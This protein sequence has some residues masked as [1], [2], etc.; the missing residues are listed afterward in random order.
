MS[1]MVTDMDGP[2]GHAIGNALEVREAID[3]LR[4]H[5]P[6]DFTTLCLE[7]AGH[8]LLLGDKTATAE[9]GVARARGALDD[10]AA[11]RVFQQLIAAQDG[12]P[13]F[14]G[15]GLP[16]AP[17][18]VAVTAPADGYVRRVDAL[19]LGV[20]ARDLGA[21]RATKS[22]A[23]DPAVGLIAHRKAGDRVRQGEALA[24]LHT[25]QHDV[26]TIAAWETRC[27]DAFALD[28]SAPAPRPLIH[29]VL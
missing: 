15:V 17:I 14:D 19:A 20:L 7:L 25:G 10:G 1:A 9:E 5:G 4:G 26:S 11:L 18:Q 13:N 8:M 22:D 6:D 28:G 16:E 3:T 24:T 27:R 21:G 23:I 2:L 29:A 12:P